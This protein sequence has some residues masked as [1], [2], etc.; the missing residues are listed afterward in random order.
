MAVMVFGSVLPAPDGTVTLPSIA[1]ASELSL[2]FY[3]VGS[4]VMGLAG[5]FTVGGFTDITAG[6][7]RVSGS[8]TVPTG[9]PPG[10]AGTD[11]II[12]VAAGAT[13]GTVAGIDFYRSTTR[14]WFMGLSSDINTIVG[15][16]MSTADLKFYDGTFRV[17]IDT[18]DAGRLILGGGLRLGSAAGFLIAGATSGVVTVTANA[19]AGTWTMELP[20][21]VPGTTGDQLSATTAGVCT[22]TAAASLREFKHILGLLDPA[23]ALKRIL[24]APVELWRY[25]KD[26]RSTTG[27]FDKLYAGVVAD[28]APWAMHHG[29]R[30]LDPISTVGHAFAAIQ[31]LN[32]RLEHLE[33]GN[34]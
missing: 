14:H 2:G 15:V 33:A 19:V 13:N 18:S 30:T 10:G 22:W 27:D 28:K 20:A 6:G 25:R 32:Q 7:L 9:N 29:G 34:A 11:A 5:G 17:F 12:T 16:V 23:L 24:E 21:A 31:A 1:F 4:A 26:A 3:R 8:A